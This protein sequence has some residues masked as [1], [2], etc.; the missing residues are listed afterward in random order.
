MAG[1]GMID[2]RRGALA[3]KA[4]IAKKGAKGASDQTTK[5]IKSAGR[6]PP[7]P[8]MTAGPAKATSAPAPFAKKKGIPGKK[9][10]VVGR[11]TGRGDSGGM[12]GQ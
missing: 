1:F 7:G 2:P 5:E 4:A 3:K 12:M 6:Q 9:G 8:P 10:P 11:N